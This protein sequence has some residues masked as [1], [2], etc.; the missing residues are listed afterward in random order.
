VGTRPR[1]GDVETAVV[2]EEASEELSEVVA[3]VAGDV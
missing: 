3:E 2:V 1:D